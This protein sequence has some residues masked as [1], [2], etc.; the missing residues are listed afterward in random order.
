M[1]RLGK[2]YGNSMVDLSATNEKLVDRSLRIL[3]QITGLSRNDALH[4]LK[5]ANG[6]VKVSIHMALSG[7]NFIDSKKLFTI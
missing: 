2:V 5:K 6:S 1:I 4:M 7:L 3:N